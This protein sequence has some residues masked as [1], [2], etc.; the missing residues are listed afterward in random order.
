MS[1]MYE[2]RSL[3]LSWI[4]KLKVIVFI[5]ELN[6]VVRGLILRG[7]NKVMTPAQLAFVG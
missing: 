3:V 6:R 4:I 7:V 1:Q 2:F 5:G